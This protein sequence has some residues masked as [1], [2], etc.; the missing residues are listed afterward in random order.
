MLKMNLKQSLR[1][2]IQDVQGRYNKKQDISSERYN[3]GFVIISPCRS[4][5]SKEENN[6]RFKQMDTSLKSDVAS[7]R[8]FL[9]V[10]G[11][12][13]ETVRNKDGKPEMEDG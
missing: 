10:Y 2:I 12:Y 4:E 5:L 6:E 9:P 11:G 8:S 3:Q 1:I 13:V 7:R